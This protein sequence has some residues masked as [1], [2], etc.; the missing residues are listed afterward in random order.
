LSET[1]GRSVKNKKKRIFII[2]TTDKFITFGIT[3]S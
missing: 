1:I 2:F 3:Y